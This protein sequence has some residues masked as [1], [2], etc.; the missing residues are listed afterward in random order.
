MFQV[1]YK[2][3][4]N[5][6]K[7]LTMFIRQIMVMCEAIFCNVHEI[8]QKRRGFRASETNFGAKWVIL[9]HTLPNI[10]TI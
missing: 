3:G 5:I 1:D 10:S 8:S 7:Y 4:G 2:R 6:L 9:V